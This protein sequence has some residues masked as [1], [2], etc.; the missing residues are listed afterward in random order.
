VGEKYSD[1][2]KDADAGPT[3]GS[4]NWL[5]GGESVDRKT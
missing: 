2:L 5:E 4:K 1:R 3:T